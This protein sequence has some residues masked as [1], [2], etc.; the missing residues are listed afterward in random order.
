MQI[1]C[2][3]FRLLAN[4]NSNV[5]IVENVYDLIIIPN[6]NPE[7]KSSLKPIHGNQPFFSTIVRIAARDKIFFQPIYHFVG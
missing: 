3:S 7:Q 5:R 2:L 4:F 6:F 1:K